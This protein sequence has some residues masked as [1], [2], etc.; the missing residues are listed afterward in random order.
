MFRQTFAFF[1]AKMDCLATMTSMYK[2]IELIIINL[3]SGAKETRENYKDSF[4]LTCFTCWLR[5]GFIKL[6]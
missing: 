4:K 3:N 6:M 1:S 2:E 5:E